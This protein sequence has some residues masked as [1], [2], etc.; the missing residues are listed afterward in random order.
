MRFDVRRLA[1]L[2]MH[3]SNGTRLRR[4]AVLIEFFVVVGL[5]PFIARPL[6]TAG[7]S[8]RLLT[9]GVAGICANY[10]PL[11]LHGV[12]LA[13][14][15]TLATELSGVDVRAELRW[16][17]LRQLLLAVPFAVMVLATV[18]LRGHTG[19]PADSTTP[20]RR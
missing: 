15:G 19:R 3:G 7:G 12:S 18:Q 8:G 1:A 9:L 2:D 10:L 4:A 16:Y 5:F 14:P 11:A 6:W 13:L 20:P 17:S